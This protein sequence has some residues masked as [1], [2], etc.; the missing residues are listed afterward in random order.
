M[1]S[2]FTT[3][4]DKIDALE[5]YVNAMAWDSY[6]SQFRTAQSSK[7]GNRNCALATGSLNP[8]SAELSN[9][10][11]RAVD[12]PLIIQNLMEER[13]TIAIHTGNQ[14]PS[15][16]EVDA[17]FGAGGIDFIDE[18]Q[19]DSWLENAAST[20]EESFEQE[21]GLLESVQEIAITLARTSPKRTVLEKEATQ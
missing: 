14:V 8:D 4:L 7:S 6:R 13:F 10:S 12:F 9:A 1:R 18:K 2:L 16:S 11:G 17:C 19:G 20:G 15:A 5:P 21:L 3:S